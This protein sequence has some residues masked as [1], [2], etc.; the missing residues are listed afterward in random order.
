MPDVPSHA[1]DHPDVTLLTGTAA[2]ELLSAALAPVGADLLSWS[3]RDVDVRPGRRT[4]AS[5][6]AK[7]SWPEGVREE[8][9]GASVRPVD[10]DEP[11]TA[12]DD[13]RLVLTDGE[14]RVEMWRFP[15]DPELP[16][17]PAVCFPETAA[18]VL[19]RIGIDCPAPPRL[20]VISYRP[21][22]RAVV[23]AEIGPLRLYIKVLRPQIALEVLRRH[24]LL[25]AAGL[26]VP[27]CLGWSDDGLLV[28]AELTGTPLGTALEATGAEACDPRKLVALLDS[29]PAEVSTLPRRRP[30]A[31]HVSHYATVVGAALPAVAGRADALA[32][33]IEERLNDGG[34]AAGEPTHGDFYEAQ[35]MVS[36]G[37]IS[38]LLDID[39][40]GPGR[41]AD[42]LACLLAHLSVR[43]TM[44]TA[45]A[46]TF[47][48]TIEQW[49]PTFDARVGPA[50]L[51]VRTAA[52][53]MSLATG[54]Y[55]TQEAGW[56]QATAD[57]LRLV[58]DWLDD[59]ARYR[60]E[61]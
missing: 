25:A 51:R 60:H 37:R 11:V 17:L 48:T 9:L 38:G 54:P 28:L 40:V 41:R 6:L 3:V 19:R 52:V 16:A 23:I 43:A 13:G 53:V 5:Y 12:P 31:E 36:G 58:K 2:D 15:F 35:L 32:A 26:P 20:D 45:E 46:G 14:R 4:T 55:R 44:R 7:V 29:L 22:R 10:H 18:E 50:E 42:D 49:L 21:R 39:T 8:V 56:E 1:D 33:Q 57:R 24:E 47:R 34:D 30:W 59:A 27:R 61:F